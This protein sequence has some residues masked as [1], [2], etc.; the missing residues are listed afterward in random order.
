MAFG[1]VLSG[2]LG[3]VLL[4][5]MTV[6]REMSWN[7]RVKFSVND[8]AVALLVYFV[9]NPYVAI[10]LIAHRDRLTSNL[11]N[12]TAMYHVDAGSSTLA[13]AL[14][15]IIEGTS[16]LLGVAGA[17]GVPSCAGGLAP[18]RPRERETARIN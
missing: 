12:S 9:A 2:A 4:P 14:S 13:N 3:I 6:V 18:R 16:P 10:N 5:A 7:D 17:C 8:I 1:M 11:S 15:L